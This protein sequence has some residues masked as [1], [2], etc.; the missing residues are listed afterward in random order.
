MAL[1]KESICLVLVQRLYMGDFSFP[2]GKVFCQQ[3]KIL[4]AGSIGFAKTRDL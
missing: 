3:G 4:D 1:G 2:Y